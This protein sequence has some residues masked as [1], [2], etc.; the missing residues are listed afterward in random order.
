[1]VPASPSVAHASTARLAPWRSIGL[2]MSA[3]VIGYI[4][5]NAVRAAFTPVAFA[6]Y[7]GVSLESPGDD[8]FVR[9]YAIRALFLGVFGLTLLLRR[10]YAVLA[11]F[12][13]VATL[14]PIGDALLVAGSGGAAATVARHAL[15]AVF[16]LLTWYFTRRWAQRLA[17]AA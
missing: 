14:M 17:A 11:L 16:L 7:F 8:A 9:V 5:F 15:I 10:S 12:T 2:W 3:I 6:A 4:L 1:M 13:L